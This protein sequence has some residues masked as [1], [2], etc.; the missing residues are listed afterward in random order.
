MN[1]SSKYMWPVCCHTDACHK[2]LV[3]WMARHL[4]TVMQNSNLWKHFG[5]SLEWRKWIEMQSSYSISQINLLLFKKETWKTTWKQQK[6]CCCTYVSCIYQ[7]VGREF[8]NSSTT[9]NFPIIHTPCY[10][11]Y[12]NV[13]TFSHVEE[14]ALSKIAT[15]LFFDA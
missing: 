9:L 5:S 7:N 1:S 10:E 15:H 11:S 14:D 13:K 3:V 8:Y 2:M 4:I 12:F 6:E